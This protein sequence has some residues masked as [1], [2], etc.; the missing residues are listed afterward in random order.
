M[1]RKLTNLGLLRESAHAEIML[2]EAH[3]TGFGLLIEQDGFVDISLNQHI[4]S[5]GFQIS[6]T[7]TMIVNCILQKANTLNRN[8]RVYPRP[9]LERE[10]RNYQQLIQDGSALGEC[11][12]PSEITVD[13]SNVSHRVIKT[14]WEG[15]TL[16]GKL[17]I[18][19]SKQFAER[20]EV[21]AMVG[22]RLAHLLQIGVKLGISSR[23]IGSVKTIQGK[24]F[25]QDDF[26]LVCYDLVSSPS[27]PN[28]FLFPEGEKMP[29]GNMNESLIVGQPALVTTISPMQSKL[30]N[31]MKKRS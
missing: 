10:D 28:A 11:N 23:G 19:V 18:I 5:E 3:Q 8:G 7:G 25:V 14:W 15:E 26:E 12:H 30:L 6:P 1:N 29:Q 22:D 17:E 9:I 31:F 24:N 27:T 20:G 16:F 2:L 13:L 4:L 21:S